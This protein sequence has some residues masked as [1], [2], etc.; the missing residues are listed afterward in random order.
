MK[1][2]SP[3]TPSIADFIELQSQVLTLGK[4][5]DK[6]VGLVQDLTSALHL[7]TQILKDHERRLDARDASDNTP[8]NPPQPRNDTAA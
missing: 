2:D 1:A 8:W 7:A 4:Q 6:V 5:L 3:S